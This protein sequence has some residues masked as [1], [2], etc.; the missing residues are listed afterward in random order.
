MNVLRHRLLIVAT[1]W[2]GR[3]TESAQVWRDNRSGLRQLN[4]QRPPHAA[5]FGIAVQKD[6]RVTFPSGQIVK[7]DPVDACETILDPLLCLNGNVSC[8]RKNENHDAAEERTDEHFHGSP[9]LVLRQLILLWSKDCRRP[10]TNIASGP[11]SRSRLE[12]APVSS[13]FKLPPFS[14]RR[15]CPAIDDVL[16]SG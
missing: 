5:G 1:N 2:L 12:M 7:S 15:D 8:Q 3:L 13:R 4:H 11:R 14:H 16:A 6:H 10:A 9:F